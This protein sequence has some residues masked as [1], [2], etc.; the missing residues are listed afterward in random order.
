MIFLMDRL[1]QTYGPNDPVFKST[2]KAKLTSIGLSQYINRINSF[3]ASLIQSGIRK[4]DKVMSSLNHNFNWNIIEQ[5]IFQVGAIHVPMAPNYIN[6]ELAEKIELIDPRLIITDSPFHF[7]KVSSA[8][9][10]IPILRFELLSLLSLGSDKLSDL[11]PIDE[12]ETAVILFTSGST[13]VSK[14]VA[15]S[16]KNILSSL[17]DFSATD[18]FDD[19]KICLDILH[20]S[21]SGGRKVNYSAQL[22]GLEICYA[23]STLSIAENINFYKAELVTCIPFLALEI[24]DYL[25]NTPKAGGSL[26]KIICG[27]APLSRDIVKEFSR[28]G[29]AI[30]DVYGL[31][32]TTSL[33]TYNTSKNYKAGSVGKFSKNISY[34]LNEKK[35]LLL[36]GESVFQGY[37]T[38]QGIKKSTDTDGWF[39]THDIGYIDEDGFLFLSGRS[40]GTIKSQKGKFL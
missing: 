12:S 22:R 3:S 15:I 25:R 4:G 40:V 6:D 38:K 10:H 30:Y 11:S 2:S 37:Y 13:A 31:T 14:A 17:N 27:G 9:K 28:Y 1:K 34:K 8:A 7:H 16:Y 35:E 20:H 32:E 21:F 33:A 5:S 36:K 39:N 24:L 23:N 29:V 26:K 19:V 18:L